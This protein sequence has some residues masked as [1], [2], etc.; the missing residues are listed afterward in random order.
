MFVAAIEGFAQRARPRTRHDQ[1]AVAALEHGLGL[2][3]RRPRPAPE[4]ATRLGAAHRAARPPD[5]EHD[6]DQDG[7]VAH[8]GRMEVGTPEFNMRPPRPQ[9]RTPR[10]PTAHPAGLRQCRSV[11]PSR[12]HAELPRADRVPPAARRHDDLHRDVPPRPGMRRDQPVAGLPRLQRRRPAVRGASRTG[13][14]PGHNQYAP[15]GRHRGAARG[16]RRQGRDAHGTAYDVEAR[17]HRHRRR[18]PG[19]VHRGDRL[20]ARATRSSCSSRSTTPT[21]PRSGSPAARV[22]RMPGRPDY[23]PDWDAVA[24]IGPRTH[25]HDQHPAQSHRHGVDAGTI[26]TAS[27]RW[28]AA[29][30]RRGGRRGL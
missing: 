17:D 9:A 13:C 23:R 2:P 24:A 22:A 4:S 26:S 25:D 28:C 5:A 18:H 11:P 12:R 3:R 8:G 1:P 10:A 20:R 15:H 29:P 19:A 7:Q 27:P 16:D 14:A 30:A 21:S 6:K